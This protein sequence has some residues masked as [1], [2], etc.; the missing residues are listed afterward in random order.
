MKKQEQELDG[1]RKRVIEMGLLTEAMV[2]EA[3]DT[4]H[5]K[6][7][8]TLISKVMSQEKLLDDMQLSIDREAIRLLTVYS[9]VAADLRF[10]MTVSRV[11][12][13]LERIRDH[14]TNLCE[15]VQL[16]NAKIQGTPTTSLTKMGDLV[17][18]MIHDALDAFARNDMLRARS[19]IAQDDMIDA[20]NDQILEELLSDELVKQVIKYY[21]KFFY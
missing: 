14:A 12:G 6:D 21:L 5:G 2:S 16:L 19:T 4:I 13:E 9:P 10:I 11:T 1:L 15:S 18:K 8:D 20:I 7:I 3:I 17:R